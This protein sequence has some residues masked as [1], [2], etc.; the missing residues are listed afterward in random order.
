AYRIF[1]SGSYQQA[2]VG[3]LDWD[4]FFNFGQGTTYIRGDEIRFPNGNY[5]TIS[6]AHAGLPTFS[7]SDIDDVLWSGPNEALVTFRTSVPEP[8]SAMLL[9]IGL[10]GVFIATRR[11]RAT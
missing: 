1:S 10:I 6:P 2:G 4:A 3:P 7:A 11:R 8:A 5:M 9:A